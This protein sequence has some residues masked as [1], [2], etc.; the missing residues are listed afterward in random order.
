LTQ[1]AS[2]PANSV[3]AKRLRRFP[4]GQRRQHD[5]RC[6]RQGDSMRFLVLAILLVFPIADLYVTARV[7]RWT[8]FRSGSGLRARSWRAG[9]V[10]QRTHRVSRRTGRGAARRA[11][12]DARLLD[13]GRKVLAGFLLILP[14]SFPT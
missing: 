7:A 6:A 9:P 2:R 1:A 4:V 3:R 12:A 13:S 11:M 5:D 14:A 8:A 10:A